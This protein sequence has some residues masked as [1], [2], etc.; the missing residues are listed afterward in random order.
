MFIKGNVEMRRAAHRAQD[1]PAGEREGLG[2]KEGILVTER[3]CGVV[4]RWRATDT[5]G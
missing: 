4:E 2:G 3:R 5:D 1:T